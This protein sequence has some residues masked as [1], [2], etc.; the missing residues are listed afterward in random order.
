MWDPLIRAGRVESGG[1]AEDL[2]ASRMPS[3]EP[4]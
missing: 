3:E 4:E 1:I 2:C